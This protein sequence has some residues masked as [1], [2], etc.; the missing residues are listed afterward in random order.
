V[1][2]GEGLRRDSGGAG[3]DLFAEVADAVGQDGCALWGLALPE[4]DAG[5]CAVSV[6]DEDLTC[7]LDAL[8]APGGV[9]K[10]DDVT[11][12][13]VDGEVLVERSNLYSFRLQITAKSEVSGM[14]PPFE[15]AIMRA[16][17]RGW[18]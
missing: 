11:G 2:R 7:G 10:E 13:G 8:N 1:D 17:R 12:R 16:P 4:R 5:R 9:A 6:F 14:A 3:G 15:M 18:R